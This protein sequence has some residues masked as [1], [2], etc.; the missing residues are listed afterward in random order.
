MSWGGREGVLVLVV[1]M[2]VSV[3]IPILPMSGKG[4]ASSSNILCGE[5]EYIKI[6]MYKGDAMVIILL[7]G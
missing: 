2:L 4:I 1:C 3:I 6:I 5:V 7:A